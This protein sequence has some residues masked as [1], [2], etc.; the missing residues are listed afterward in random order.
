MQCE[1]SLPLKCCY[2]HIQR[3]TSVEYRAF[4][5]LCQRVDL[6]LGYEETVVKVSGILLLGNTNSDKYITSDYVKGRHLW[7]A[8]RPLPITV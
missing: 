8:V 6:V 2:S 5:D 1:W 3:E 4:S 7:P